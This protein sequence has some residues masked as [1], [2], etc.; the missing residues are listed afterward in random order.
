MK[1]KIAK[2]MKTLDLT[3]EEAIALIQDDL[4][5][6][7]MTSTKQINSDLTEEQKKAS[8]QAR[9][10]GRKIAEK[11]VKREKKV[12]EIKKKIL[13]ALI[14]GLKILGMENLDILNDEREFTFTVNGE[15]YKAVLSKPR[16]YFPE[17]ERQM[18]TFSF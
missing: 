2:L 6:D 12:D 3:E 7:R 11:P 8:K 4:E 5:V 17:E 13:S 10:C 9:G 18:E 16:K 14:D 15:K 1:E